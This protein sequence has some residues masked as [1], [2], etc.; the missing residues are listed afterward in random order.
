MRGWRLLLAMGL[1]IMLWMVVPEWAIASVHVYPEGS[2]KVMVR[3]LRN[4]PDEMGRSWQI[5]LF[6]R[7]TAGRTE[8]IHLRVVGFPGAV[9]FKHG[10]P[11]PISGRDG[12][13]LAEDCLAQ[14]SPFPANTGE[15]DVI[16]T[17]IELNSDARLRLFLPTT[18]GT[19]QLTVP[20]PV[21]RE[22]RQVEAFVVNQSVD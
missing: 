9:E 13:W 22:W 4:L 10:K 20:Q 18:T 6:K 2:G 7:T 8:S 21:V 5:V 1:A 12:G 3:S 11:L 15:Y 14:G 16:K 19:I 17:L